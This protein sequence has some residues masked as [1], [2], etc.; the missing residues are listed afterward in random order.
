MLFGWIEYTKYNLSCK[1]IKLYFVV[2][3]NQVVVF[4]VLIFVIW[5]FFVRYVV[6]RAKKKPDI[7]LCSSGDGYFCRIFIAEGLSI[8]G[9]RLR[10]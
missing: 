10:R 8:E 9:G 7:G 3:G 5:R 2:F 1:H 4:V 6:S